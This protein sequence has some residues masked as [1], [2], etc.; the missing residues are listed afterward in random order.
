MYLP[1]GAFMGYPWAFTRHPR[2]VLPMIHDFGGG[3]PCAGWVYCDDG[4]P[5]KYRGRIFHC[6]WGKGKVLAV[7]VRPKGAGFEYVDEIAFMDPSGT[8]VQDFRPFT[9]RPTADGRGFY[10]SDWGFSGWSQ[11]LKRGRIW[12]VTYT[13][14]DVKP[15]PRGKDT[16]PIEQLIKALDHSA[17][18][19]RLRA[20]RELTARGKDAAAQV[21][22]ALPRLTPRG[23]R[24][25]LWIVGGA[26]RVDWDEVG[27]KFARDPD[28]SVRA[29]ALRVLATLPW[30]F[31]NLKGHN[32]VQTRNLLRL[33]FWNR[34]NETLHKDRAPTVRLQAALALDDPSGWSQLVALEHEADL[35]VRY[36]LVHSLRRHCLW[37]DLFK[38][39]KA[40][41]AQQ[42]VGK[43]FPPDRSKEVI[44]GILT[45]RPRALEGLLQAL[46][47]VYDTK[48]VDVLRRLSESPDA[49]LRKRAVEVLARVHHDRKPYAGGWWGTR[50][51]QQK[52]PARVVPWEGT[53]LVRAA[54]LKALG[55]KTAEVR[56]AA[57]VGLLDMNDP[58]TLKPMLEQFARETDVGARV[59]LVRAIGGLAGADALDFLLRLAPDLKQPEA[60][61]LEA[62]S[63]LDRR[64]TLAALPIFVQV[65]ANG[66]F[67]TPVRIRAIEAI[68]A[69]KTKA[70]RVTLGRRLDD[71]AAGVRKAAVLALAQI[72]DPDNIEPLLPL[73]KDADPSVRSA[74]IQA[75]GALKAAKAVPALLPLAAQPDTQFEAITALANMPDVRAL[76]AYL[77]GLQAKNVELRT[78]CRQAIAAIRAQ[79]APVLEELAKRNE[80]PAAVVPELRAVYTSYAPLLR[81]K[82]IGPFPKDG[83]PYPPE[84]ELKLAA[85]Y[86]GDGQDVKWRDGQ[87]DPRLHGKI[88]L[89]PLYQPNQNVVAYGH[90]EI[91]SG[92]DR[93]ATL[94][95]GSDDSIVL[96]LNGKKVHEFPGDRA[97]QHNADTVKV[98]LKK[99]KNTLLVKC[100]Q[101]G[102]D[103][104]FSVAVSGEAE[105][106]AFLKG[107]AQKFDLEAFRAYARKQRGDAERGRR[108]F[109]DLKGLAC[110]KCHAVGGQGGKVGPDLAGIALRYQREDLMTS[111]L[112]PSKQI[113][114][115]YETLIVTTTDGKQLIGVFK[116]ETGDA[117]RLMDAEGQLHTIAKKDIDERRISPLS[118]MPNGLADGMTLQDFADLIAY[119]EARRE[120]PATPPR[121]DKA[122]P[123]RR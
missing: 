46:T 84:K 23:K 32:Q 44:P 52:P 69:L 80:V 59:D 76:S 110:S 98:E 2:E 89:L 74:T 33:G 122:P 54:L 40:I 51:E 34:L 18:S 27:H 93:A 102:G 6:E 109:F 101:H 17:H 77:T 56:K 38:S 123:R 83:K 107:G 60:L 70:A 67:S 90:A 8:A 4:L 94:Q 22:R 104:A 48:A 15:A 82:L 66:S 57:V 36:A 96:W 50:P 37:G 119:L 10:V 1:P 78:A 79:A 20:Q 41:Q 49:G 75:L 3:S 121:K 103:W 58:A 68:G 25:A 5:E 117:V 63:A 120:E 30:N 116:G 45:E 115:G 114:N 19:E 111:V 112:E 9:L 26:G 62:I 85:V 91:V 100:G 95:V 64:R 31:T 11:P 86:K 35:W 14:D 29:E 72:A 12:K 106:Y 43:A 88:N 53:P 42:D 65:S 24:H 113:A 118:T 99:G 7:K 81:W 97:W 55:D 16:D 105:Q 39:L 92:S 73:L 13:R 28:P 61:R 108:L 21:E 87:G 71:R 47:E